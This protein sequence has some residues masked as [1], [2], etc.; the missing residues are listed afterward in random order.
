MKPI[1]QQK[2]C[3]GRT[4]NRY[5]R[6]QRK[7]KVLV[8]QPCLTLL[9]PPGLYPTRL[10]SL[11]YSRQEYWSGL[12]F[13]SPEDPPDPGID[14]GLLHCRWIL[15]CLSHQGSPYNR[16]FRRRRRSWAPE[17]LLW[18]WDWSPHYHRACPNNRALFTS[19]FGASKW[20]EALVCVNQAPAWWG[21]G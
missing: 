9:W 20:F 21:R 4:Y 16:Y 17:W 10:L 19:L 6:R 2:N 5:F 1:F 14:S 12:P 18:F 8:A 3:K 15:H 13:P 11:E 7:V